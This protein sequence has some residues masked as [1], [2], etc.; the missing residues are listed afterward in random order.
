MALAESRR[1]PRLMPSGEFCRIVLGVREED[2]NI[3][4]SIRTKRIPAEM[5]KVTITDIKGEVLE[6]Y[7]E[8]WVRL[9][10]SQRKVDANVVSRI[11]KERKNIRNKY[12]KLIL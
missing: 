6:S 5:V 7:T 3:P 10:E 12:I 11:M 9:A 4:K 8:L 1:L 2:T